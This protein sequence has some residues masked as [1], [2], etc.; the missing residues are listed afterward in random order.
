MGAFRVGVVVLALAVGGLA[1]CGDDDEGGE[2]GGGTTEPAASTA[3]DEQEVRE[4]VEAFYVDGLTKGTDISCKQLTDEAAEAFA[5]IYPTKTGS[6]S[7]GVHFLATQG[8]PSKTLYAFQSAE[9]SGD[10]ATA[11]LGEV[12]ETDVELT[13]VD[14][15]WLISKTGLEG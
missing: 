1:G 11:T 10:T 6:C 15:E 9:V 4:V 8:N 5:K 12:V 3:A 2:E 14:G 7:E 13:R